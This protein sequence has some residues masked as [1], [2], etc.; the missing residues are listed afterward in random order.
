MRQVVRRGMR[1]VAHRPEKLDFAFALINIILLLLFFFIVTGS[2]VG[3]NE[4]G[5]AAPLTSRLTTE[6]LPRPLLVIDRAGALFLDEAP[7]TLARAVAN[8]KGGDP[9]LPVRTLN[10]IADR[11]FSA[12]RFLDVL[13]GLR[14]EGVP[15]RIITLNQRAED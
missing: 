5:V 11:D 13:D 10:V 15:V 2:I 1:Q 3:R 8:L 12:Q 4:A 7:V 9:A 14:S 6:R